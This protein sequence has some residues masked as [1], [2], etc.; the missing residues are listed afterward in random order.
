MTPFNNTHPCYEGDSFCSCCGSYYGGEKK[1]G[2]GQQYGGITLYEG[3]VTF[4]DN[5]LWSNHVVQ[6]KN[7]P[8]SISIKEKWSA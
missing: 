1:G 3:L 5:P 4:K 7:G 8:L 2:V 6:T